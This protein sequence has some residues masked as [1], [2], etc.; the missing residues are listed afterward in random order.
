VHLS[1]SSSEHETGRISVA[2]RLPESNPNLTN[3]VVRRAT[4]ALLI[5][6]AGVFGTAE[7]ASRF[8]FPRFSRIQRRIVGDEREVRELGAPAHNGQATVLVVGNSLLLYA[9][10]YPAFTSELAPD[11]KP[12]RYAIENTSYLD[13]YY[14]LKA[15]FSEG[16]R[17]ST[18]VVCLNLAQTLERGVLGEYT[19]RHLFR[20]QDL[21]AVG[22]DAGLDNTKTSGLFFAHWS[23]FYADRAHIRNYILNV[24]DPGYAEAMNTLARVPPN[25][26]P[27]DEA[28]YETRLRLRTIMKLCQEYHVD[29]VFV[30]PPSLKRRDDLLARAGTLENIPV[31][32]PVPLGSLGPIY[33]L[34]GF[35][36]N[37]KGAEVFTTALARDLKTRFGK[38]NPPAEGTVG[39]NANPALR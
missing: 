34:D 12:V 13:W 17:P 18:V 23:A 38:V 24:S 7:F 1:T 28:V 16:V 25:L 3:A 21:L 32:I 9:L 15:L 14:G 29:F 31:D 39:R 30:V 8:L 35:H 33:F 22:R 36:L 26:P 10:D 37:P 27:D 20:A 4:I 6:L 5:V 11:V 19:A 2:A